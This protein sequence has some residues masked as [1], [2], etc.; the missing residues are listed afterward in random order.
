[1]FPSK[2]ATST[3]VIPHSRRSPP[4]AWKESLRRACMD[5]A[6]QRFAGQP[7][8]EQPQ[9]YSAEQI[10]ASELHLSEAYVKGEFHDNNDYELRRDYDREWQRCDERLCM[11]EEEWI[12]LLEQVACELELTRTQHAVD[13]Q[14]SYLE[15]QI[16]NFEKW[17][18]GRSEEDDELGT[19]CPICYNGRLI[20]TDSG[21]IV[22][23]DSMD[24][25]CNMRVSM[26]Q[27]SL[28]NFREKLQQTIESHSISCSGTVTFQMG[29]ERAFL[30]AVCTVC[31]ESQPVRY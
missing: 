1:M 11:T 30:I 5:R 20:T 8:H 10:I 22:C 9:Q 18:Q 31:H 29:P 19:S 13:D 7:L 23:S 24:G 6:R 26:F 12:D 21:E 17:Q 3:K 28:P 16:A 25:S 2:L 4:A 14:D 27:P 15:Q